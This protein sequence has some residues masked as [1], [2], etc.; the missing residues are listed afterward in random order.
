MY[1]IINLYIHLIKFIFYK[2]I[3]NFKLKIKD[4]DKIIEFY[5]FQT[6]SKC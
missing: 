6:F 4:K 2:P 5:K 3:G 1:L